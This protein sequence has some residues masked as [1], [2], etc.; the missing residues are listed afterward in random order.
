MGLTL[1]DA[2]TLASIVQKETRAR[3]RGAR[4]RRRLLN[5]LQRGMRLQADPT[6]T[7]ALKRDGKWTGTLYR[8]DYGYESALQHLPPRRPAARPDLQPGAAALKAAVTPARTDYLYF[9]ADRT[10][11]HTFSKTFE[12]HLDAIAAARR[13]ER[14]GDAAPTPELPAAGRPG[15]RYRPTTCP[16][17]SAVRASTA[18]ADGRVLDR[19]ARARHNRASPQDADRKTA[20]P[21]RK[22][23]S[24]G[25]ARRGRARPAV[26]GPAARRE[27]VFVRLRILDAPELSGDALLDAIEESG[28]V[29]GFLKN[30][31]I[32]R[33]VDMDAVDGVPYIAW[34]EPTA[35]RSPTCIAKSRALARRIP[36]EH[37]LLIAEKV[38]T[39]LDHAYNTTIDGDRTLHGLVWPGFVVDLRR[40]RDPSRRIRPRSGGA[41]LDRPAAARERGRAL[42]RPG[43]AA[44]RR[45]V[46]QNSDVFSVGVLLLELLT[47]QPPPAG[48]A[49]A[50]EGRAPG[51]AAPDRARD[52]RAPADDPRRRPRARYQVERRSAARARQAPL[53]GALLPSTFNLAYFLNDLFRDEIEAKTRAREREARLDAASAG[54]S[55]LPG[56]RPRAD[57][58]PPPAPPPARRSARPAA[59]TRAADRHVRRARGAR[60]PP[61][62]GAASSSPSR[63]RAA[64]YVCRA[65]PRR[66]ADS[67]GRPRATDAPRR[68]R[69]CCRSSSR[70]PRAR[71]PR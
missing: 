33:G 35:G 39:A 21:V 12:E 38:A 9:V 19:P 37:A 46:G 7:Y 27:T 66:R 40:R 3:P 50:R 25:G 49:R 48:S 51:A 62:I 65:A 23:P 71:R 45:A 58:A 44:Q 22:L 70:R 24:D 64:I 36:V 10:G 29:H 43:R 34:N 57:S 67:G 13:R 61:S 52:P 42:P 53:L 69:R 31:A 32:A 5:R 59:V 28:E 63:S 2:V 56:C 1:R 68:R 6:V 41:A 15:T 20:S 14:A 11:G 8:S 18:R 54:T 55:P 4:H 60:A 26:P 30:P 47:G 16:P 17:V